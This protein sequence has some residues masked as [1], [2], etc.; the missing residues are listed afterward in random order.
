M[1]VILEYPAP[2][3]DPDIDAL[4]TLIEFAKSKL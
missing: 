3:H 4:D 2:Y 1:E